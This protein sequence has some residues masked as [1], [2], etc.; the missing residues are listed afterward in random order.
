MKTTNKKL[1]GTNLINKNKTHCI[2]GHKF[3]K[4]N[5]RYTKEGWRICKECKKIHDRKFWSKPKNKEKRKNYLKEWNKLNRDKQS[6]YH[7][8]EYD[9]IRK[10]IEKAKDKPCI[11]CNIKY[12]YYVMDF[13]HVK[14]KKLI[15]I[16]LSRSMKKTIKEIEKCVVICS[17]CHRIRTWKNKIR[18]R[19]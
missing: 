7:K 8:R 1:K 9:K 18:K 6:D 11:D 10:I 19:A 2:R 16:G 14:G 13:H 15:N 4:E 3:T 5:T 17:N 12:P